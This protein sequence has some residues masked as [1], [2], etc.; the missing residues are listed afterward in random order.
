MKEILNVEEVAEL[1][2]LSRRT[3]RDLFRNGEIKGNKIAGKYYTTLDIL[4]NH[5]ESEDNE[6]E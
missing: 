2:N 3:V 5:I 4:K 6:N 1:L